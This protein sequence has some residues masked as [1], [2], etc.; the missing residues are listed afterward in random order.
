MSDTSPRLTFPQSHR[1][2]TPAEFERCYARKKSASDT[3]LIVY[4]CENGLPH[5]RL[6]RS[7]SKKIGGAVVRNRYK[8][9][10]REAFRLKQHELPV[11]IDLVVIPRPGEKPTLE[12]IENSLIKLAHQAARK[13]SSGNKSNS[14]K[15]AG[16]AT[17]VP[18][19]GNR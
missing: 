13:L 10:F 4:A 11:G 17:Q 18:D 3:L 1:M 9:L 16:D 15:Q 8:R 14:S 5:P 6:G 12:T 19:G 7:V 2:K